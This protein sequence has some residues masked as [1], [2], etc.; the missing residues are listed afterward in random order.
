SSGTAPKSV[1]LTTC[2]SGRAAQAVQTPANAS[3]TI[4]NQFRVIILFLSE[5][6]IRL[7]G[8]ERL[9]PSPGVENNGIP[10]GS[11][12]CIYVVYLQ[13]Y[14][15]CQANPEL[16]P[17]SAFHIVTQLQCSRWDEVM[18]GPSVTKTLQV[19]DKQIGE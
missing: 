15:Y 5:I 18:E 16:V 12:G 9:G 1:T 4:E 8:V 13:V 14:S 17:E 6:I 3:V 19:A 7:R 10:V 11:R 2:P